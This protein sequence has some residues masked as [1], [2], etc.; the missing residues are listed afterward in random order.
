MPP[1]TTADPVKPAE[2]RAATLQAQPASAEAAPTTQ[3]EVVV[4]VPVPGEDLCNAALEGDLLKV[5]QLL[6]TGAP[7]NFTDDANRRTPLIKAAMIGQ[8]EVVRFLLAQG[9]TRTLGRR[10]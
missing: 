3:A 4:A 8:T 1:A 5:Q 9:A 7:I 2:E 6:E 10:W